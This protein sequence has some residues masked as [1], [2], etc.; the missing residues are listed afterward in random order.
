MGIDYTI[1]GNTSS[2]FL[3]FLS[4]NCPQSASLITYSYNIQICLRAI[5]YGGVGMVALL[6]GYSRGP[7]K[8]GRLFFVT[9][10]SLE[11]LL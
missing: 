4:R 6:A 5:A 10:S 7:A 1:F 8:A 11:M 9:C 3:V 2:N